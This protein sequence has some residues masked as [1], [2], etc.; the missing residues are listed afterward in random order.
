MKKLSTYLSILTLAAFVAVPA[1]FAQNPYNKPDDSW[2]SI[3]GTVVNPTASTFLL[4][5]GE[6]LIT[7]EMDDWDWYGEATG[8]IDGD[9]VTVYGDIDDDLY[10]VASIEASSV[11]VEDLNTFFYA[12]D[13]DEEDS[14]YAF[15]PPVDLTKTI[16][17]GTVTSVTGREF[18]ID[19]G[20]Q[21]LTVDTI[22]MSYNPL[23]DK[24]Y[25]QID[26]GDFVSVTG[27]MTL[28][29]LNNRE[30]EADLILTLHE[31]KKK[32]QE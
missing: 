23:D 1:M 32:K 25:Q 9:Q 4:D 2:I 15:V 28:D 11:W 17:R 21:Q 26:K 12:N 10:E 7:V 16:V 27:D 13:A 5:Y 20:A 18:T 6:G 22:F 19:T 8:L 30:L 3:S 24:G 14:L 31:D 29:F